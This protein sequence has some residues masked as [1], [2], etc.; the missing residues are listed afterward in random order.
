MWDAVKTM[1]RGKV[2]AIQV[3]LKEMRK[4]SNK[5]P[6]LTYKTTKQK[7]R[8]RTATKNKVTRRKVFIKIRAEI[9]EKKMK[10][11]I[12]TISKPKSWFFVKIKLRNH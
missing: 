3:H 8:G 1:Q 12:A 7:I 10:E 9:I 5:Q 4:I 11:T 2:I 6:N